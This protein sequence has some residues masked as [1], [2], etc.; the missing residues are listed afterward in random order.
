MA[1]PVSNLINVTINLAPLSAAVR[2][3]GVLMIAGDSNVISGAERLRTYSNIN[4]V[5]ADFGVTAP[6]FYAAELYFG[7]TPQPAKL[8]I[9]RWIRAATSGFNQGEILNSAQMAIGNFTAIT[10]GGFHISI[11]G[12]SPESITGL[13]FSGAT[14]LNGVAA[15][16]TA[17]LTGAICTFDGSSFIITSNSTGAG[18]AATGTIT[19]TAQPSPGDTLTVNGTLITFVAGAAVGSQ[20][21]IGANV[22]ATSAALQA[23]LGASI[24]SNIDQATYSSQYN[25]T[26]VLFKVVG[27]AGN[28]FTLAKSS[29][30]ITLSAST[31]LG[32][33]VGSSVGYA[34]A[35]SSGT[36]ISALL[37]LTASTSL[38]LVPGYSAESPVQC[39]DV[40]S[41][42][43]SGWY[44]SMF[45]ASV[46]PTDAQNIAVCSFVEALQVTRQ[47]GVTITNTNVLSSLVSNDLA[48][49]MKSEGYNQCLCQ[50]SE[51][52]Y[53]VASLFGRD[54]TVDFTAQNSTITLMYKQEPSVVPETLSVNQAATL[55]NKNCNVFVN[56]DNSTAIVQYGVMSS[57]EYIDTIQGVDWFQNAVQTA[58]Y[59]LLYT[60][61]TKIPQTDAGQNQLSNAIAAVCDQAVTNGLVA[62][63]TWTG[64]GF[65]ELQT[66]QYLKSGYYIFA[67]PIALQSQS[68][69]EARIAPPIQV[70]IKLAGAIQLVNCIVNVNQ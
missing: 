29:S 3:F 30:A 19:L 6:E 1:L 66:G 31:L 37:G 26:T 58:C 8:M 64:G 35:P 59:N 46:M 70:A 62:P 54:A 28:S 47:F 36:D 14:N 65:G 40:L 42:L 50:Y 69:R 22:A 33:A 9:G 32:G 52:P 18:A 39:I 60:S 27:T 7:Q 41:S 53:A 17:G 20:I 4:G 38:I 24:D 63:G 2:N 51:N 44:N 55:Q 56:Y 45:A 48:S 23:F 5:A 13:N 67:N 43:S 61:T 16:V 15:L 68:D 25:I 12:A 10:S 11:D 21:S 34:T 57:G 49:Q